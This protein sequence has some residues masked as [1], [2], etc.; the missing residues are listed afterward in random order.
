MKI[1]SHAQYEKIVCCEC[2]NRVKYRIKFSC[3]DCTKNISFS[4][5]RLIE[6]TVNIAQLAFLW[7]ICVYL[8]VINFRRSFY[9]FC[10]RAIFFAMSQPNPPKCNERNENTKR[11]NFKISIWTTI[12]HV[13]HSNSKQFQ[14]GCHAIHFV[15]F[16]IHIASD[17]DSTWNE[18][19]QRWI[20][21]RNNKRKKW[22][23]EWKYW[24]KR[25]TKRCIQLLI[26]QLCFVFCVISFYYL[27]L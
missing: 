19:R 5:Y 13:K 22:T 16:T 18:Q 1:G 2:M 21:S 12:V 20:E 9:S 8:F 23:H 11:T 24:T 14:F 25:Q 7:S 3:F 6:T 10:H 4:Y 15:V 27:I 17:R 26:L